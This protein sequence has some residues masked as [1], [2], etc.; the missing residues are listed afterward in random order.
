MFH[1][2]PSFVLAT[3]GYLTLYLVAM[4]WGD[5][6]WVHYETC[7]LRNGL[8]RTPRRSAVNQQPSHASGSPYTSAASSFVQATSDISTLSSTA[9]ASSTFS[10][11]APLAFSLT[12][13][14]KSAPLTS[15]QPISTSSLAVAVNNSP[16]A[17][18]PNPA[19]CGILK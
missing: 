12:A 7:S 6:K 3:K 2:V 16:Y 17:L 8:R 9:P 15:S 19:K 4:K 13:P 5:M 18:S 10:R 11:R 1:G 14:V